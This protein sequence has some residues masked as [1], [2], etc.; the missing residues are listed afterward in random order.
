MWQQGIPRTQNKYR[1][2][3][4]STTI[5]TP[6][7]TGPLRTTMTDLTVIKGDSIVDDDFLDQD[8]LP[9]TSRAGTN[10]V[11]ADVDKA[12]TRFNSRQ[13]TD[14]QQVVNSQTGPTPVR[15]ASEPGENVLADLNQAT[16]DVSNVPTPVVRRKRKR[17]QKLCHP[18]RKRPVIANPQDLGTRV[19]GT[20][21]LLANICLQLHNIGKEIRELRSWTNCLDKS[22]KEP[23]DWKTQCE[24]NN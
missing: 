3:T 5:S 16:A 4:S 10:T 17:A 21:D 1:L 13:M 9:S 23:L 6:K 19:E 22:V 7:T 24:Q 2:K 11:I 8:D 18:K 14:V 20:E 15:M 12:V